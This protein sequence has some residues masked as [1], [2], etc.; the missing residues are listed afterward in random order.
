MATFAST[1]G[2]AGGTASN[3]GVLEL[4]DFDD[5]RLRVGLDWEHVAS[6][7]LKH[8]F[9]GSLSV[10][11]DW[12]SFGGDWQVSLDSKNNRNT[13]N[14]GVAFTNDEIFQIGG[15]TP[16]GLTSVGAQSFLGDGSCNT[17]D[18]L[19][20]VSRALNR[21]TVGQFT[22]SAGVSNGYHNDPYKVVS[23]ID[24]GLNIEI[25][26]YFEQRPDER[27]RYTLFGKLVHRLSNARDTA[28][29]SY[30]Y[31]DDDWD[32]TSHTVDLKYRRGM[33][34]GK[35]LE[36]HLRVYRQSTAF[37]YFNSLNPGTIP[38]LVS[39]DSRLDEFTGITLG[40]KYGMPLGNNGKFRSR[41]EYIGQS[42][43]QAQ[44]DTLTATLFQ[45]SYEKAF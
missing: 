12:R 25:D 21:R 6:R 24:S 36:P 9:G 10:D 33:G 26:C 45:L 15:G 32:I 44:F 34:K 3:G 40:L 22:V 19:L 11:N 41:A 39:A 5:T 14:A 1:S 37:F 28:N 31:Y 27:T 43:E 35:F 38:E 29:I 16:Q 17:F 4:A 13:Y 7:W 8:N 42:F 20:G 18:L 2:G 23:Q 30:R